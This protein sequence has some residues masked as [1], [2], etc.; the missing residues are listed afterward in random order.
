[1]KRF[2]AV[3]FLVIS[4]LFPTAQVAAAEP[5][6]AVSGGGTPVSTEHPDFIDKIGELFFPVKKTENLPEVFIGGTPIGITLENNGVTVIG[7]VDVISLEGKRCPALEIGLGIGDKIITL[8]GTEINNVR[9]LGEIANRSG[10]KKITIQYLHN[11]ETRTDQIEPHFDLLT[12]KYKLGISAKENSS[13]I[14]TLTFVTE[15]RHFACL[16]HPITD[17]K[18]G[19]IVGIGGGNVF[20]CTI[21]GVKKGTKGEA[22]ELQGVFTSEKPFGDVQKNNKYGVY[23]VFHRTVPVGEK[24][25]LASVAEVTVGAAKIYTTVAGNQPDWYE[26]DIVKTMRQSA[27]GDKGM[28]ISV[29]DE[30]LRKVAGGIVQGMSGSPIVQNGKLV[31]AVTH[32]FVN[33]PTKGYGMYAEWMWNQIAES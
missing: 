16:G 31:G 3:V 15:N 18:T 2:L 19:E 32:V 30:R 8:D 10:G 17:P 14:G 13:G 21:L 24:F 25:P 27:S 26:I 20:D 29:T 1:M 9:T 7:L 28:V 4:L 5:T 11:G 12:G 33:A 6:L 23:G 22:G